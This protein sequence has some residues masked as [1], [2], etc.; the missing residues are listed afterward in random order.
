MLPRWLGRAPIVRDLRRAAYDRRFANNTTSTLF[1]GNLSWSAAAQASAPATRPIGYDNPESADLY[2]KRPNIDEYRLPVDVL[3]RAITRAG[4][5]AYRRHRRLRR[6]QVFHVQQVHRL[7]A[8]IVWRVIDVPAVAARGKAFAAANDAAES[9]Q[10]SDTL[11]DVEE[12]NLFF[13]SGALQY[14]PESLPEM[15]DRISRRPARI[16]INTTP[17][18]GQSSRRAR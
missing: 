4:D 13:F 15:L 17:I 12:M 3:D 10:C 14:L 9:L 8:D 16:V 1:R 6:H 7:P 18:A 5:A 2:L 11:A